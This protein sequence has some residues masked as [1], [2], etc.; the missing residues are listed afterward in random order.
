MKR[1]EDPGNGTSGF[2]R[3]EHGP[4]RRQLSKAYQP[5]NERNTGKVRKTAGDAEEMVIRPM[6][7]ARSPQRREPPCTRPPGKY[8][9]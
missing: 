2:E 1:P 8:Q 9:R 7:A 6:N 3:G 4:P 5:R